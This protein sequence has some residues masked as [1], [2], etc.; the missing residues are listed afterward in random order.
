MSVQLKGKGGDQQL[1]LSGLSND[2]FK[3][4]QGGTYQLE[5]H[6][7]GYKKRSKQIELDC[8]LVNE[9]NEVWNFTYLWRDKKFPTVEADLVT[10][11]KSN[12][13]TSSDTKVTTPSSDNKI[14]G[15]VNVKVVIDEDGN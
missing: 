11:E 13:K 4:L 8:D 2:G 6:K 14:F 7:S 15:K 1:D 5:F 3:H 12:S 10:D 9:K